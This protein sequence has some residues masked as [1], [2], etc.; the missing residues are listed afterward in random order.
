MTSEEAKSLCAAFVKEV[1]ANR[2][3]PDLLEKLLK[4][5]QGSLTVPVPDPGF[6]ESW[7]SDIAKALERQNGFFDKQVGKSRDKLLVL[8]RSAGPD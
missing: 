7:L 3:P 1:D 2:E 4:L 5:L 6:Y 8:Q